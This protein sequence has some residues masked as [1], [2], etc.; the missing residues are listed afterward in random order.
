MSIPNQGKKKVLDIVSHEFRTPLNLV[1]G[2]QARG[3]RVGITH[4][5]GFAEMFGRTI[6]VKSELNEASTV[7]LILPA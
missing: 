4:G 5:Q 7:T 3:S 6:A 1:S 2:A